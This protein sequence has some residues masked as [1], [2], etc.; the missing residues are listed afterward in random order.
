M[1]KNGFTC[2]INYTSIKTVTS[3]LTSKLTDHVV[4]A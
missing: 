3:V 1:F 2:F 4:V